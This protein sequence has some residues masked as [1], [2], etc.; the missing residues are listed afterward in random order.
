MRSQFVGD[1][2]SCCS[3][4]GPFCPPPYPWGTPGLCQPA[5]STAEKGLMRC[6][7]DPDV[8]HLQK[9]AASLPP[10]G[11]QTVPSPSAEGPW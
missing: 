1:F 8:S 5:G 4:L 9:A 3:H 2:L 6:V 7:A 11:A 10:M